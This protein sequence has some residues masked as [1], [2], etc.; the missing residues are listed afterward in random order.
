[1]THPNT[2]LLAPWEPLGRALTD[3]FEGDASAMVWVVMEDGERLPMPMSIFFRQPEDFSDAEALAL[4]LCSGRVLDVGA[5]AGCHALELQRRGLATTALDICPQAVA[6]M[7]HRGVVDAHQGTLGFDFEGR[8]F[9]T[10]LMLMNGLGVVG[11]LDGLDAFLSTVAHWLAPDGQILCDSSDLRA[12]DDHREQR[13]GN[14]R[15]QHGGYRGET[16]QLLE[17][18]GELGE[19]FGWL[20]ADPECLADHAHRHGFLSQVIFQGEEGHFLARLVRR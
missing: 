5:G 13:R 8:P 9:D 3:S 10:V 16:R 6:I 1:M 20:Y 11:D 12:I 7:E 17:Y 15:E 18:D 2:P 14:S 4:D 19:P